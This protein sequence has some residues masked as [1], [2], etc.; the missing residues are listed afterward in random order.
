MYLAVKSLIDDFS[1]TELDGIERF[2]VED[3]GLL[4]ACSHL[5]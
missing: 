5:T 1:E 4:L 2:E 3:V